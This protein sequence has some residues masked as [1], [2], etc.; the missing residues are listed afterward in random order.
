MFIHTGNSTRQYPAANLTL[1]MSLLELAG[2]DLEAAIREELDK[3]PALELVDEMRCPTCKRLVKQLP[4]NF[5]LQKHTGDEA[6]VF[7]SP[8][9]LNYTQ[10]SLD[11]MDEDNEDGDFRAYFEP[12][13]LSELIFKQIGPF[14]SPHEM[15]I[16]EEILG[17]L[18]EEGFLEDSISEIAQH[19]RVSPTIVEKVLHAIQRCEPVGVASR[20]AIESMNIQ[21][22]ELAKEGKD[23]P[24]A[25][26]ILNQHLDKLGRKDFAGLARELRT[27]EREIRGAFEF[28]K[29]NLNPIP[30]NGVSESSAKIQRFTQADVIIRRNQHYNQ[31][32]LT[33][34]IMGSVRGYLRVQPE[35][36]DAVEQIED[37]RQRE[38]WEE[39]V[40]RANLFAKCVSQRDNAMLM[41]VKAI[42]RHQEEFILQGNACAKK[43]TRAQLAK[44][45]SLH[46]STISRT[47]ANKLVQMPDNR[48]VPMSQFFDRSLVERDAVFQIIR[49]EQSPLSDEQ[50]ALQLQKDYNLSVARR[51][52]AKYRTMLG[53]LPAS[54]RQKA[55]GHLPTP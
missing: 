2:S 24:I 7:V 42:V 54:L 12:P 32:P 40:S 47:V 27:T 1:T 26:A 18:T 39:Q 10:T 8:R 48:L 50:I 25:R 9:S 15:E 33:V 3:N 19:L 5:C 13:K 16:A 20:N 38:K 14:L 6:F 23:Q 31:A 11:D 53:I 28:I 45:L 52:V 44:E 36:K 21:L 29:E 17:R 46:E 55:T 4:C 22:A 34:E 41:I 43:L 51:T 35:I 49:Q 30:A 37:N